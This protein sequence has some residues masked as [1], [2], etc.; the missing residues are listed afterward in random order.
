MSSVQNRG[1]IST[2]PFIRFGTAL[3]KF[4]QTLKQDAGR[5]TPLKNNTVMAKVAATQKWVPLT[6]PAATD[7]S[8]IPQ[9]IYQGPDIPAAT[10]V[11]GDVTELDIVVGGPITVDAE[12]L[13][14]ENSLTLNSVITVGTTDLRTVEDHLANRG[15][16]VENTTNFDEFEN[17]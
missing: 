5:A 16:F 11:A 2:V 3:S 6:N 4:S 14:L 10:I 1:D 12:Q 9:G 17:T 8:S 7:G 13:I 15:I